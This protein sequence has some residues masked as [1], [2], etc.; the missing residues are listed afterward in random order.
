MKVA[1]RSTMLESSAVLQR[2]TIGRDSADGVTQTFVTI[3]SNLPCSVQQAGARTME[4]YLQRN[5][6]VSTEIHFDQDPGCQANDVF[7]IT[8][9]T[10]TATYYLVEGRAQPVGRGRIWKVD[11]RWIQQPT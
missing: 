1:L 4:I 8:D 10:N 11:A 9:R 6:E 3:A 5:I 2:P 7:I